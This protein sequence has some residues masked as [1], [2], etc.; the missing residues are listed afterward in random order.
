MKN[1]ANSKKKRR[2][3]RV[4]DYIIIWLL[5]GSDNI[6]MHVVDISGQ[7]GMKIVQAVVAAVK[8]P[9]TKCMAD[10]NELL[11]FLDPMLVKSIVLA[12][13]ESEL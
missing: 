9:T 5:I 6:C 10:H 7:L 3:S 8:A 12:T 2:R 11:T 13:M 4:A 1:L